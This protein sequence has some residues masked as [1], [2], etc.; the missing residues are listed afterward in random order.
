MNLFKETIYKLE[1]DHL[2]KERS[3]EKGPT[4]MRSVRERSA[5]DEIGRRKR[6][7]PK[8]LLEM[9][10]VGERDTY[11]I[12]EYARYIY[13]YIQRE[14]EGRANGIAT[15]RVTNREQRTWD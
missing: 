2:K 8:G 3:S 15:K 7:W 11:I 9:R 13:I 1:S 14:R 6:H 4:K 12:E 5:R 10:L